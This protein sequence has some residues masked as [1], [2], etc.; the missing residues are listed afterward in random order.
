MTADSGVGSEVVL[1]CQRQVRAVPG[2]LLQRGLQVVRLGPVLEVG[3]AVADDGLD[4]PV[5]LLLHVRK[6]RHVHDE[7]LEEG[8]DGVR[9][10]QEDAVDGALQIEDPRLTKEAGIIQV[11]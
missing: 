5:A 8:R 3:H 11:G 2:D 6:G 7:P 10:C 9:A 4:L 1:H